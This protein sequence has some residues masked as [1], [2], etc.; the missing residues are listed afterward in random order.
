[1]EYESKGDIFS[2]L[3]SKRK[4]KTES[5]PF[6][7]VLKT[8]KLYRASLKGK[9][10]IRSYYGTG[11]IENAGANASVQLLFENGEQSAL[12]LN[13]IN[14][15][16]SQPVIG[17][18]IYID[19]KGLKEEI[20]QSGQEEYADRAEIDK[21]KK[22]IVYQ[23]EITLSRPSSGTLG[24]TDGSKATSQ[25][26]N[27][28]TFK[29]PGIF[30]DTEGSKTPG[31]FRDRAETRTPGKLR[32]MVS[33]PDGAVRQ[34]A[35]QTTEARHT[36]EIRHTAETH[37]NTEPPETQLVPETQQA[38]ELR[39]VFSRSGGD[40]D[41]VNEIASRIWRA[42]SKFTLKGMKP[43]VG[44]DSNRSQNQNRNRLYRIS[45]NPEVLQREASTGAG[46]VY[47]GSFGAAGSRPIHMFHGAVPV[48]MT[49]SNAGRFDG[50]LNKMLFPNAGTMDVMPVTTENRNN[51]SGS[52]LR[53]ESSY[54]T[55]TGDYQGAPIVYRK[56]AQ[57]A[58]EAVNSHVDTIEPIETKT[59]VIN[60]TVRESI[61]IRNDKKNAAVDIEGLANKVYRKLEDRL[62]T[63]R[64][65]RGLF[66]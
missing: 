20:H 54:Q 56:H 60:D 63:E 2:Q 6:L 35:Q 65:R 22:M 49:M 8:L 59:K 13:D 1:M 47:G 39:L 66:R 15:S 53:P 3:L 9:D 25:L 12:Q 23:P 52:V 33:A 19:K 64:Q 38:Q 16:K 45:H 36:T 44:Q 62:R 27:A 26:R 42:H 14:R 4:K 7:L 41:P 43:S 50:I 18:L 5:F 17:K 11:G 28:A 37:H 61:E 51:S 46:D 30:R 34:G 32:G 40:I 55:M 24:D 21:L 31:I 57:N 58:Q 10:S 29:A 48:G